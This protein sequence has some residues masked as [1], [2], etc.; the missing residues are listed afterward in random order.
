MDCSGSP[1]LG[2]RYGVITAEDYRDDAG[3][4]DRLEA[5]L[6]EPVTLLYVAWDDGYVTV[7]ITEMWSKIATPRLGL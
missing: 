2:Q 1:E 6:Y 7:I 3:A 5:L 4:V